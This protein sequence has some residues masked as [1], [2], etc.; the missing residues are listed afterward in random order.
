MNMQPSSATIDLMNQKYS[1]LGRHAD[2]AMLGAQA[3]MTNARNEAALTARRQDLMGAQAG[4]SQQRGGLY[5]AEAGKTG[6]EAQWLPSVYRSNIGL[7]NAQARGAN[8]G[9]SVLA[10][11]ENTGLYG[12]PNTGNE[13]NVDS[14][15]ML[16]PNPSYAGVGM[17]HLHQMLYGGAG[18]VGYGGGGGGMLTPQYNIN[19]L[20]ASQLRLPPVVRQQ[21]QQQQ[22]PDIPAPDM[23]PRA[24]MWQLPGADLQPQDSTAQAPASPYTAAPGPASS[25][26]YYNGVPVPTG[27]SARPAGPASGPGGSSNP[28]GPWGERYSNDPNVPSSRG[29]SGRG[30]IPYDPAGTDRKSVV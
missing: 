2:A 6:V 19:A 10:N 30:V 3:A 13:Y 5:G 8:T 23:T 4:E 21:Q 9:A 11:E 28:V 16:S 25:A 27:A 12:G 17:S 1:I 22:Q 18:N 26:G 20:S 29:I 15:G 24:G 7:T 14:N